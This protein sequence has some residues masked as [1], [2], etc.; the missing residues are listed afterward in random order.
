MRFLRVLS[1]VLLLLGTSYAQKTPP[2]AAL[3]KDMPPAGSLKPVVS[4]TVEEH[5]L[6]N[7]MSRLASAA[8]GAAE[9]RV[10][11]RRPRRRLVRSASAPG[12]AQ[13]MAQMPTGGYEL[14][15]FS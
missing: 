14:E 2:I 13:L 11:S 12:L 9:S 3:P 6:P 5:R 4:P 1:A 7:G 10:Y 8:F 15:V